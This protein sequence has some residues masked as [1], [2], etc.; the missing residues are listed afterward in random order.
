MSINPGTSI[1]AL[2]PRTRTMDEETF[3]SVIKEALGDY[4]LSQ[5]IA[6]AIK[7]IFMNKYE[8]MVIINEKGEIE[9]LDRL[10]EKVFGISHGMARGRQVG[11]IIP[12]SELPD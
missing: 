2:H 10:S 1:K 5:A 6:Q 8:S 9:F 3:V 7:F 4:P 11:E 12:N